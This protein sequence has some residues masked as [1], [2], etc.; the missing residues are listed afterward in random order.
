EP[1][2]LAACVAAY[3]RH[4]GA[5]F[6]YGNAHFVD[7]DRKPAGDFVAPVFELMKYLKCEIVPPL[8]AGFFKR[9]LLGSDFYFDESLAYT[10]HRELFTRLAIT[11][12]AQALCKV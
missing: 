11:L 5:V 12:R 7:A 1:D 10:A 2:A 9:A 6:I 8:G 3:Q 4:P